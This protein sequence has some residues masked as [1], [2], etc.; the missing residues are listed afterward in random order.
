MAIVL[1]SF[2]LCFK[3]NKR[4]KKTLG[5]LERG[6]YFNDIISIILEGYLD[7]VI[8]GYYNLSMML[9]TSGGEIYG[10]YFSYFTITVSL[11]IIPLLL[12]WISFKTKR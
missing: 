4:I 1:R 11:G 10:K 7:I 8:A 12:I 3:R 9:N 5:F 2:Y 6:T